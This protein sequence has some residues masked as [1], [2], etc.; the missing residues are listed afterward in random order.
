MKVAVCDSGVLLAGIECIFAAWKFKVYAI[1]ND[2]SS[3][4]CAK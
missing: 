3:G 1:N 4:K 2:R